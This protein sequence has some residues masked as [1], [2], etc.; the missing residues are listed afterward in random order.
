MQENKKTERNNM[1]S[2]HDDGPDD[3][4]H[5]ET[6]FNLDEKSDLKE[7]GRNDIWLNLHAQYNP[8][9]DI[10]RTSCEFS[11][12]KGSKCF[13]FK[14]SYTEMFLIKSTITN[15]IKKVF[16]LIPQE[17]WSDLVDN[18]TP[19]WIDDIVSHE[20]LTKDDIEIDPALYPDCDNFI[21]ALIFIPDKY[22][23]FGIDPNQVKEELISFYASYNPAS[24]ELITEYHLNVSNPPGGEW[25]PYIAT[26]KEQQIIKEMITE[27]I[28]E[29]YNLTPQEFYDN[30][31]DEEQT[32]GE[33]I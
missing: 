30:F 1:T 25:H 12:E 28:R 8:S 21:V 31:Y 29:E 33:P 6:W 3:I 20:E 2:G 14:P 24:D 17:F 19:N 5:S 18:S 15:Q 16:N 7:D 13:E 26:E 22:E 23:R 4:V 9:A 27:T 11:C 10:I 32:M